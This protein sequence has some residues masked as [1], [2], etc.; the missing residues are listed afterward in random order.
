M[1]EEGAEQVG[2]SDGPTDSPTQVHVSQQL[3]LLHCLLSGHPTA[4]PKGMMRLQTPT[5]RIPKAL[6]NTI[7]V[8]MKSNELIN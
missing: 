6:C 5:D 7:L 1:E 8:D 3:H 2:H 4:P